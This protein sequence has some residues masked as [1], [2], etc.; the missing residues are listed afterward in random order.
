MTY[1]SS[2]ALADYVFATNLPSQSPFLHEKNDED[3]RAVYTLVVGL[4]IL[5]P[6]GHGVDPHDD[7]AAFAF[8]LFKLEINQGGG[9]FRPC[10]ERSNFLNRFNNILPLMLD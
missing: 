8:D 3:L 9:G 6:E 4:V 7:P 2:L 5:G 10:R 1:Y